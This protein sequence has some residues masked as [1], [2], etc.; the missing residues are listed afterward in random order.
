[1]D[2]VP[3][4]AAAL[5]VDG[6]GPIAVAEAREGVGLKPVVGFRG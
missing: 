1:M 4:G 2:G 6:A 5:L 3:A